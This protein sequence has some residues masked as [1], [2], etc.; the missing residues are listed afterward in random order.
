[1][2]SNV[3]LE[4][5]LTNG[6]HFSEKNPI[7]LDD[8]SEKLFLEEH[9]NNIAELMAIFKCLEVIKEI[10][11]QKNTSLN[12]RMVNALDKSSHIIAN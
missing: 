2:R 6:V 8:I 3:Y 1:M 12:K 4:G 5:K 10:N 7:E 9:S 11:N